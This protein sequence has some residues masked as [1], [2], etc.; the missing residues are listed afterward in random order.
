MERAFK[1]RVESQACGYSMPEDL[2]NV[3]PAI[4]PLAR[5]HRPISKYSTKNRVALTVRDV[6]LG[7]LQSD[8]LDLLYRVSFGGFVAVSIASAALYESFAASRSEQYRDQQA[9]WPRGNHS[10]LPIT[11]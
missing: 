3:V 9:S 10:R 8:S 7:S 2:N 5:I 11:R 6:L 1:L 4:V